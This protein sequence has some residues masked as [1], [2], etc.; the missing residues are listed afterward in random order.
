MPEQPKVE[1][2]FVPLLS[3][4][5]EAYPTN[6]NSALGRGDGQ[7]ET[8]YLLGKFFECLVLPSF[9]YFVRRG[10]LFL[11]ELWKVREVKNK[12]GDGSFSL[13]LL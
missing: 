12:P 13:F 6:I 10:F 8:A 9:F 7:S 4:I 2:K 5:C 3:S 1:K 11:P